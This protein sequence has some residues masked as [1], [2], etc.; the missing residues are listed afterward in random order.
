[1]PKKYKKAYP[2]SLSIYFTLLVACIGAF[3]LVIVEL[4]RFFGLDSDAAEYTN[5]AEESL[6]AG[7][8]PVLLHEYDMF[9]LEGCF[10]G[11]KFK[12]E[13]GEDEMEALL[14]DKL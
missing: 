13:A 7:Y 4:A 10:G 2:G 8:Q 12:I 9:W 11:E 6:F 5:L 1:M 3:I 14:Y